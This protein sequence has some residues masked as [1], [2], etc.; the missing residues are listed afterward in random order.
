MMYIRQ[1]RKYFRWLSARL[2]LLL[3]QWDAQWMSEEQ[4]AALISEHME[5]V[6]DNALHQSRSM[7]LHNF[8]VSK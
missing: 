4:F 6:Q 3:N 2:A 8:L 1:E 5:K 7:F